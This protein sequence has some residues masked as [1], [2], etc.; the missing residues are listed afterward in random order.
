MTGVVAKGDYIYNSRPKVTI[1]Q[2][3][4]S[5]LLAKDRVVYLK[6]YK[7]GGFPQSAASVGFKY[8]APKYWFVGVNAN[9]F[10][11]IYVD[12]NP[13]RRTAEAMKGSDPDM[14]G[15][16]TSDPQWDEILAQEQ[17]DPGFTL[18]LYG[19]KS[20]KIKKYYI[21]LNVSVN[22]ILNNTDLATGGFEQLRFDRN[23]IDKF[24][25]KYFYLYGRTYFINLSCRF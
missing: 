24:P 3:N 18:N 25:S 8:R 5:E 11:D 4:S 17:L 13:D 19:G 22:N 6:N 12:I 9:Y 21:Y 23:D 10:D 7:V 2:D 14:Q 15:I 16:I 1:T 20:W